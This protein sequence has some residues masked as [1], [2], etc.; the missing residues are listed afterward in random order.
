MLDVP[1]RARDYFT[2]KQDASP[3]AALGDC[4]F[5]QE[6]IDNAPPV[7][8]EDDEFEGEA[9]PATVARLTA[10]ALSDPDVEWTLL[11]VRHLRANGVTVKF[12]QG[13]R[14]RG[15]SYAPRGQME[16]H[17]ASNPLGGNAPALGIV[18]NGRSDL[19]GPLAQTLTARNGTVYI[20][21][22]GRANHAGTGGPRS[23]IPQNS[24][25]SF[26]RGN[27]AENSGV[28][29]RWSKKQ[30]DAMVTL[31][32]VTLKLLKRGA[33]MYMEHK[34]WTTRKIDRAMQNVEGRSNGI[35]PRQ[36][37]RMVKRRMST[38]GR[39]TFVVTATKRREITGWKK[40]RAWARLM[41]GRNF[42]TTVQ[43]KP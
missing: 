27:E 17:T 35:T 8:I 13:W 28:G 23:G 36:Y 20:V 19:P 43:E 2:L 11:L 42:K 6:D 29:E 39:K 16:H 7:E 21:A 3:E 31:D 33:A 4:G 41:R 24:G 9:T 32:A 18:T 38:L 14:T 5:S 25:N 12:V 34:Q 40:A 26:L 15:S 1:K 30:V 37:R 22:K 10:A